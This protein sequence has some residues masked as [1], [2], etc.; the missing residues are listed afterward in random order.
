[1][2]AWN[3]RIVLAARWPGSVGTS[4]VGVQFSLL[5]GG[6][7]YPGVSIARCVTSDPV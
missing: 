6:W 7:F 5:W 3:V 1:M 2:R 4:R